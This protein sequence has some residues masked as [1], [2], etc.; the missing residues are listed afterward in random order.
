[1]TR[2][3]SSPLLPPEGIVR[4]RNMSDR[5]C[6]N[7]MMLEDAFDNNMLD[8]LDM[9]V[10]V[11]EAYARFGDRTSSSREDSSTSGSSVLNL[12]EFSISSDKYPAQP[13]L[14]FQMTT[15]MILYLYSAMIAEFIPLKV[16]SPMTFSSG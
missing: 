5:H 6:P 15:M 13:H 9:V 10:A 12:E 2:I 16:L 1:M 4:Y 3:V 11:D 7:N 8:A 14:I